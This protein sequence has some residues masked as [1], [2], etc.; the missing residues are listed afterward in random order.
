VLISHFDGHD[1]AVPPLPHVPQGVLKR[2]R[3]RECSFDDL[4]DDIAQDQ[5]IAAAVLRTANSPLYR[6]LD[7]ITQLPPAVKRLGAR[8]LRTLMMHESLHAALFQSKGSDTELARIVWERALA[9]AWIM[10]SLAE[11]VGLDPEDAFLMGLLHDIGNVMVLRQTAA[12]RTMTRYRIDLDTFDYFCHEYHQRFG[13]LIAGSW[14][15]P[16]NLAKVIANHHAAPANNDPLRTHRWALQLSD[17][18]TAQLGYGPQATYNLLE[19]APAHRL[20]L[21]KG[22]AFIACLTH[23]PEDL[24]EAMGPA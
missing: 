11:P 17:L 5:V 3:D 14:K 21:S 16:S 15:L 7:K 19:T 10:R 20:G 12:A 8:A 4:A 22:E 24:A 2:L 1:L 18:I 23:L 6:G 13:E 9:G